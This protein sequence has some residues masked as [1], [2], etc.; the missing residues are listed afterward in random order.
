MVK[1]HHHIHQRRRDADILAELDGAFLG[2]DSN[3]LLGQDIQQGE[4]AAITRVG[5]VATQC[6]RDG[7]LQDIG[8]V[9]RRA[10]LGLEFAEPHP[11]SIPIVLRYGADPGLQELAFTVPLPRASL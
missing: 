7:N 6:W 8:F 4:R 11:A 2:I 9:P 10:S 1:H 3:V 5:N